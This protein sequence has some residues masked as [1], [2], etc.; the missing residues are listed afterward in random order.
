VKQAAGK[1]VV[2]ASKIQSA[3]IGIATRK[4]DA[5]SASMKQAINQLYANGTMAT[6]LKKW[7]MSAFA[8]KK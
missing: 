8:L 2:A 5:L 3:P 7:G 1:F 6:I 4:G